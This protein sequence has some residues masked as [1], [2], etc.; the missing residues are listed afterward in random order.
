MPIGGDWSS[1]F[2]LR[3]T[4]ERKQY[5]DKEFNMVGESKSKRCCLGSASRS[6]S[7]RAMCA[8]ME[9]K[10]RLLFHHGSKVLR[11]ARSSQCPSPEGIK[12]WCWKGRLPT[13]SVTFS[14]AQSY[15]EALSFTTQN[16]GTSG[17]RGDV[18]PG[19]SF[20]PKTNVCVSQSGP[21][22]IS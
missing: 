9:N 19:G 8:G 18:S 10:A 3:V 22:S 21:W 2:K 17:N 6:C 20:L 13:P 16:S 7:P 14:M 12:H 4:K 5:P 15:R 11:T 1:F